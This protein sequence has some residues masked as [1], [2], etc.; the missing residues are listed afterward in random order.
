MD[1]QITLDQLV[2][3]FRA[4]LTDP[5]D[6]SQSLDL[7]LTAT[8]GNAIG[9]WRRI[10]G[11]LHR[12]GFR[13]DAQFP[14]DVAEEFAATTQVVSLEK[15]GLGIVH[16]TLTKQPAVALLV[17]DGGSL[18]GSGRWL[19]RWGS[20]QSLSVPVLQNNETVA[21]LA[22]S[23]RFR[24]SDKDRTWTLTVALAK[25]LAEFL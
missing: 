8:G 4:G 14:D 16:A 1:E 10:G 17:S 25:R 3:A 22:L 2:E 19:E 15:T 11:D 20:V 5:I 7:L 6:L 23:T 13:R 12:L 9:M 18:P 21:V 24:F